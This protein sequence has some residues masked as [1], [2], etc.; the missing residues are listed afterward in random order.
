MH[1][2]DPENPDP[3]PFMIRDGRSR[4][5]LRVVPESGWL[6]RDDRNAAER[7]LKLRLMAEH[8]DCVRC[9]PEGEQPAQE[10]L[11]LIE[12][13]TGERAESD[14]PAIDAAGAITK[15]FVSAASTAYIE[16]RPMVSRRRAGISDACCL[17]SMS[18]SPESS[19][20]SEKM[21]VTHESTTLRSVRLA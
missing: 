17:A 12:T 2:L 21:T 1:P 14:L 8:D 16:V 11:G 7:A 9:L 13:V 4:I 6:H 19:G 3:P 20:S 10:L 5:G 15:S 18:K